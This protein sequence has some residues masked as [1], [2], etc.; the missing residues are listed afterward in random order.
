MNKH[1]KS[2]SNTF[3]KLASDEEIKPGLV[4]G[5]DVGISSCGWAV[6]NLEAKSILAM[7]SRCFDAPEDP[8]KKTLYNAERRA[9]RGMRRV[10]YRRRGRLGT[11]TPSIFIKKHRDSKEHRYQ[12]HSQDYKIREL[13]FLKQN[14]S[15]N[16]LAH[17]F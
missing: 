5:L 15:V 6:V 12:P 7:G 2:Q 1:T 3:I 9:K 17:L 10:T 4:F 11:S 14:Q 8:Q 16:G 13:R